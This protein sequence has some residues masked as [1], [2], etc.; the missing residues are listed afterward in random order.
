MDNCPLVRPSV[1]ELHLLL[2]KSEKVLK[3]GGLLRPPIDQLLQISK[4]WRMPMK[5]C[6]VCGSSDI[7]K[8]FKSGPEVSRCLDCKILFFSGSPSHIING[9]YSQSDYYKYLSVKRNSAEIIRHRK[10]LKNIHQYLESDLTQRQ[11]FVYDIGA[12]DGSFLAEAEKLGYVVRGS[13]LSTV[14]AGICLTRTG[15]TLDL[16]EI[17]KIKTP[18]KPDLI[19]L[20][21]VIAHVEDPSQFLLRCKDLMSDQTM[22]FISTPRFC[23]IDRFSIITSRLGLPIGKT[24]LGRRINHEHRQQ[25][26]EVS[27]IELA[28]SIGLQTIS[29]QKISTY[30]LQTSAYIEGLKLSKF[31]SKIL[32]IMLDSLIGIHLAPRNVSEYIFMKSKS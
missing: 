25:F 15:I 6:P 9:N 12:G 13:E 10:I 11:P 8:L 5:P 24:V 29:A 16:L 3:N 17:E 19:T 23:F 2:F 28:Q 26:N 20:W 27:M 30:S 18:V 14:A 22:L 1:P 31:G 32:G 7:V 21:C 4:L